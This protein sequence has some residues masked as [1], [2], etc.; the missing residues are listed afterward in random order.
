MWCSN[1]I[2]PGEY[3]KMLGF[4]S[5]DME[6]KRL[7]RHTGKIDFNEI[8]Q[9][10]A[11]MEDCDILMNYF[12]RSMVL[13]IVRPILTVYIEL[14]KQVK[15]LCNG[16]YSAKELADLNLGQVLQDEENQSE[17]KS[18]CES[19]QSL[20]N[21]FQ[22]LWTQK[23][24]PLV[25]RMD[26][27]KLVFRF[28]GED[29]PDS[30]IKQFTESLSDIESS[31]I[32]N[33]ILVRSRDI[34]TEN[35]SLTL[36]LNDASVIP[37]AILSTIC[38][39]QNSFIEFAINEKKIYQQRRTLDY[40]DPAISKNARIFDNLKVKVPIMKMKKKQ[41]LDVKANPEEWI[42]DM[43]FFNYKKDG[44]TEY[45][46]DEENAIIKLENKIFDGICV[47]ENNGDL[48]EDGELGEGEGKFNSYWLEVVGGGDQS[49]YAIVDGFFLSIY[50]RD[51][52]QFGKAELPDEVARTILGTLSIGKTDSTIEEGGDSG[53]QTES[54]N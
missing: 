30:R 17:H 44:E 33:F 22:K 11:Y 7:L 2:G 31:P 1:S 6:V 40:N 32:L 14:L 49:L 15:E 37:K 23:I 27:N 39:V 48:I 19:I 12:M 42:K 46:I 5:T 50:G 43:I 36:R 13:S 41:L 53:A 52:S 26:N 24:E 8:R 21:S 16:R 47:V 25:E 10:I 18:L 20:F 51:G 4:S 38:T 34:V 45:F 28:Q 29:L 54:V 3:R 35:S 9:K